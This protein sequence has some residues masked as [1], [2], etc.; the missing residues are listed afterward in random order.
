VRALRAAQHDRSER[1]LGGKRPL[2]QLRRG[3][4]RMR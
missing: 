3:M 1:Q 4:R 2:A